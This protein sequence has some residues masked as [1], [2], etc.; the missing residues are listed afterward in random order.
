MSDPDTAKT[1][2]SS[3]RIARDGMVHRLASSGMAQIVHLIFSR[4]DNYYIKRLQLVAGG[5][6]Y[7]AIKRR[8]LVGRCAIKAENITQV[9]CKLKN[10]ETLLIYFLF[11]LEWTYF[12]SLMAKRIMKWTVL[13]ERVLVPY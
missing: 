7:E 6:E 10:K 1:A 2:R 12:E 11:R 5:E 13:L 8:F 9:Y 4:L 3:A